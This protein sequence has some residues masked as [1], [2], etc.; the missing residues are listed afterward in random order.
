M[1]MKAR[2]IG[3]VVLAAALSAG[4]FFI[5][6]RAA[7]PV[8]PHADPERVAEGQELYAQ[9]CASCH[10][11]DMTGEADWRMPDAEG[12]FPA[13]PHDETGH[14]WHHADAQLF[15]IT[16]HGTEAVVG[17]DYKSRMTGFGEVLT[18]AE[19]LSVL[20]YIKSTWP[21]RVIE[22]HNEINGRAGG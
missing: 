10:G 4:A 5:L 19:I 11:D 6:D 13:P 21:P 15:T 20:A 16:K 2:I 12:Y 9:H 7:P 8:I 18:D 17:G 14:T 1:T 22:A 3:A